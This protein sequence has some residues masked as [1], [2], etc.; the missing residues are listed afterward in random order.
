MISVASV[1]ESAGIDGVDSV[2][3]QVHVGEV[4]VIYSHHVSS[5]LLSIPL[6]VERK[7]LEERGHPAKC[8]V[9]SYGELRR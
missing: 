4:F 1:G 8:E 6:S 3:F 7:V 2:E 9:N 5:I